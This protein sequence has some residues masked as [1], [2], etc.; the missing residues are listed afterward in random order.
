KKFGRVKLQKI[1]YL[2]ET[3]NNLDFGSDYKKIKHAMGPHDYVFLKKIE[4]NLKEKGWF[5]K[6]QEEGEKGRVYYPALNKADEYKKHLSAVHNRKELED[7]INTMMDFDLNQSEVVAT[8]YAVWKEENDYNIFG[9]GP[10]NIL[11]KK[12]LGWHDRKDNIPKEYWPWGI[13]WLRSQ[14]LIF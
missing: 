13:N 12:A 8:L 2:H 14:K 9:T 7:L 5:D 11:I 6:I 1:L 4:N 3:A 10:D